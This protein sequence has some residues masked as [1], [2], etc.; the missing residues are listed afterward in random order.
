[1]NILW[2][3]VKFR[4]VPEQLVET[5]LE[6]V[7]NEKRARA[8][9]SADWAALIWGLASLGVSASAEAMAAIN[10]FAEQA[11]SSM[12]VPELCNVLW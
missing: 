11:L 4:F 5:L 1:M 6:Y 3:F 7:Q 8:F 9:R 2:A 12:T 10:K